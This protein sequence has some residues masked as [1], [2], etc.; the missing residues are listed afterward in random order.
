MK[1][2]WIRFMA[3]V[4]SSIRIPILGIVYAKEA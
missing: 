3:I 1:E 2:A 4:S